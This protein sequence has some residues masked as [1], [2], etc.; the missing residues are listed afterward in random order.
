MPIRVIA[1]AGEVATGKSEVSRVLQQLL[2]G[3]RLLHIGRMFR[4]YAESRGLG[5]VKASNV[6]NDVYRDFD[7]QVLM[8][9]RTGEHLIIEGRMAG[10]LAQNIPGTFSTWLYAPLPARISRYR[11]K[12]ELP[13]DDD[14]MHEIQYR[15]VRDRAKLRQVYGLQ[16]YRDREFYHLQVDTAFFAPADAARLILTATGRAV[17]AS[18]AVGV[19]RTNSDAHA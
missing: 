8:E 17:D 2:P 9:M 10:M 3:W 14:A 16:D 18:M 6:A 15:D 13:G 11:A 19:G 7:E 5:S 12:T 1:V 4:A